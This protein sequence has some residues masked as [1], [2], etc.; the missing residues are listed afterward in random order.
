MEKLSVPLSA[1]TESGVIVEVTVPAS[2]LQPS[3]AAP[4]PVGMVRVEGTLRHVGD[5]YLFT[6]TVSGTYDHECDRCLGP[7]SAPFE[8]TV[9]WSFRAGVG[10]EETFGELTDEEIELE[11]QS[12]F[13]FEGTEIRLGP[14]V[15]EELVLNAPAKYL[16]REDCAGLCPRCGANLNEGPCKCPKEAEEET[17]EDTGLKALG[18]MFPDLRPKNPEE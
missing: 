10:A 13:G 2:Q 16:C 17:M 3:G 4:V 8:S 1:I 14:R 9:I 12:T 18:K 15:W 7:V 6:G 5:E 11:E